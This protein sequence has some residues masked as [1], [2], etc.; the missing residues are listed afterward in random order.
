MTLLVLRH[1]VPTIQM[2]LSTLLSRTQRWLSTTSKGARDFLWPREQADRPTGEGDVLPIVGA[3]AYMR[4]RRRLIP[5][6]HYCVAC[7]GGGPSS[8]R[9][10]SMQGVLVYSLGMALVPL[11][12]MSL[13]VLPPS[14]PV[15]MCR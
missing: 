7:G 1:N 9:H 11:T 5:H 8:F 6:A 3:N 14:E 15:S 4:P 10:P 2:C 12:C 13:V